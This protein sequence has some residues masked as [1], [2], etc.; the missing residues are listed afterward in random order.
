MSR[1][2]SFLAALAS[3]A[4]LAFLAYASSPALAMGPT[5]ILVCDTDGHTVAAHA[6]VLVACTTPAIQLSDFTFDSSQGGHGSIDVEHVGANAS[7]SSSAITIQSIEATLNMLD[8]SSSLVDF[9]DFAFSPYANVTAGGANATFGATQTP[10]GHGIDIDKDTIE[11]DPI[12]VKFGLTVTQI[13]F[14]LQVF[15]VNNSASSQK[16]SESLRLVVNY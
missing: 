9:I 2:Y 6:A 14:Q 8:S 1:G 7:A 5:H 12:A 4:G 15:V 10:P 11:N 13:Q 3:A 16:V